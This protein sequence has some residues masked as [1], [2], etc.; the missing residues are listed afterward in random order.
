VKLDDAFREAMASHLPDYL[1][2]ADLSA[3]QDE[4]ATRGGAM[5]RGF[6][7]G[8]SIGI[9]LQD[10][11]VDL[12]PGR[13]DPN[14][15]CA[16]RIHA[17]EAV[18][19]R[20]NA[21]AS[22]AASFLAR[23]GYRALPLPA[24]DRTDAKEAAA[25][26]SHKMIARIAGLG[27]IGKSCL[28]ITPDRGPRVRWASILTDAPFESRNDPREQRCGACVACARA[29]PVG[30]IRGVAFVQGEPREKRLDFRACEDYFD[31]MKAT[32]EYAVCGMCLYACPYGR[33]ARDRP[34]LP[35]EAP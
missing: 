10:A 17:Y 5:V 11:I 31:E 20:L 28:L 30:A 22:Y 32:R 1:G 29:C 6:R 19:Q 35:A 21:A 26:V 23:E 15:S 16:Y 3:Y 27:W 25:T 8:V 2:F 33:K 9:A 13:S 12:L 18:N 24:A 7:C 14:V 34:I 4:L